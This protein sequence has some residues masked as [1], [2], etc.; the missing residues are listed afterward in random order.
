MIKQC[1]GI[2]VCPVAPITKV[3]LIGNNCCL[4]IRPVSSSGWQYG[5]QLQEG[6]SVLSCRPVCF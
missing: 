1:T 5:R 2:Y 3:S 6:C 4:V